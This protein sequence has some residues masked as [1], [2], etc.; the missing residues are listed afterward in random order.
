MNWAAT[1]ASSSIC[2]EA[3]SAAAITRANAPVITLWACS[4]SREKPGVV[5]AHAGLDAEYDPEGNFEARLPV[6]RSLC[7]AEMMEY[8]Q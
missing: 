3:R 7:Q 5:P 4:R 6:W 8:S 1:E 2:S